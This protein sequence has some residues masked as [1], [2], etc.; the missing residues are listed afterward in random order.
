MLRYKTSYNEFLA[1]CSITYEAQGKVKDLRY[2]QIYFNTLADIQPEIASWLRGSLNDP[3]YR[4]S[5]PPHVHKL[6]EADWK[7]I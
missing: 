5:V 4:D 1:Y 6:V 2:G 3:F 7:I